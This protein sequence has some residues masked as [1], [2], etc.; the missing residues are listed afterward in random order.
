MKK[1]F[2]IFGILAFLT[3]NITFA[4]SDNQTIQEYNKYLQEQI[5]TNFKYKGEKNTQATLSFT[6]NKNG[7]VENIKVI[8]SEDEELNKQL[9]E[10]VQ[11][12]APFKPFPPDIKY[13]SININYDFNFT[14]TYNVHNNVYVKDTPNAQQIDNR[15][16]YKVRELI[17]KRFPTSYSWITDSAVFEITILP[18]GTIKKVE[19]LSSSGSKRYDNNIIKTL[20]GYRLPEPPAI[21]KK[22]EIKYTFD[23]NK[24]T[25]IYPPIFIPVNW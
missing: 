24:N 13:D 6:V 10:A 3:G 4:E 17:K 16:Y 20:T 15:Y 5:N 21:L 23:M 12:S 19:I 9:I 8:S 22:K 1:W 2:I 18:N 14:N 11:K 25:R 7:S